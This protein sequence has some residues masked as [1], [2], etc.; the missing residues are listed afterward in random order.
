MLN[1]FHAWH[2]IESE[3]TKVRHCFDL[4]SI[5]SLHL[6]YQRRRAYTLSNS[7]NVII[8][9]ANPPCATQM[10]PCLS[11]QILD[12]DAREH[13]KLGI[14]AIQDCMIGEIQAVSY[15]DGKPSFTEMLVRKC[16]QVQLCLRKS[17]CAAI[18]SAVEASLWRY[19]WAS[20]S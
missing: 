19:I 3:S 10:P 16:H 8:A 11:L 18:R 6:Q 4:S 5:V 15:L 1:V 2:S 7:L 12:H 17:L 13:N 20:Q 9:Y 14:N